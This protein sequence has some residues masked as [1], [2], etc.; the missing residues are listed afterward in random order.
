MIKKK[1]FVH[2]VDKSTVPSCR[3]LGVGVAANDMD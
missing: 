2:N 3:I 1:R